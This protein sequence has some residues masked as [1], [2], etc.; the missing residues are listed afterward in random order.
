MAWGEPLVLGA[1]HVGMLGVR[2]RAR[3]ARLS[4]ITCG[5]TRPRAP[6]T[7]PTFTSLHPAL[8][9]GAQR[10]KRSAWNAGRRRAPERLADII[11]PIWEAVLFGPN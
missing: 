8:I 6:I 3:A 9:F 4:T 11:T 2:M 1:G 7:V 10:S 5:T